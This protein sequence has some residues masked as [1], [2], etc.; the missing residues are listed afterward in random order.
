[1]D[2]PAVT[3]GGILV[4]GI[5]GELGRALRKRIETDFPGRQIFCFIRKPAGSYGTDWKGI[6]PLEAD[7]TCRSALFAHAAALSGRID[8]LIHMAS[9]RDKAPQRQLQACIFDG[10]RD[11]YEFAA[12]IGCPKF[13]FL[14]SILAAGWVYPHEKPLEENAPAQENRLCAFGKMK[15]AT[16]NWLLERAA[17]HSP[18][19]TV[20]RLGNVYGEPKLSFIAFVASLLRQNRT[21]FYRR[22]KDSVMWSPIHT[23]DVI[24][25][26][27]L[28]TRQRSFTNRVYFLTGAQQLNLAQL[29]GLVAPELGLRTDTLDS[30]KGAHKAEY[31]I[32]RLY[33]LA[34]R[35]TGR[36]SF[37]DFRFC[38]RRIQDELGF[39]ARCPLEEGI[40]ETIRWARRDGL[41]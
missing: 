6:T 41:L 4:T 3:A 10:T 11:L 24:D 21:V 35:A 33:D 37:P 31:A 29:A 23:Q 5:T 22:A 38:T 14:S 20:L 28:L 17:S 1:M 2:A 39:T 36:P 26:L 40:P 7:L 27:F 25:A 8:T 16:E 34:R 15:R 18:K 32:R 9:V 30:L 13:L 19:V 12:Q